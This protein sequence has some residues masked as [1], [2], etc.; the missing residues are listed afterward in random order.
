MV[1]TQEAGIIASII[2]AIVATITL[3][4]SIII[5]RVNGRKT[6]LNIYGKLK[7]EIEGNISA[8]KFFNDDQD[9]PLNLDN[10]SFSKFTA[11]LK[12][13]TAEY[14]NVSGY[15]LS[16]SCAKRK[17]IMQKHGDKI[18]N[19]NINKY[20]I[21]LLG[22]MAKSIRELQQLSPYNNGECKDVNPR[23]RLNNLAESLDIINYFLFVANPEKRKLKD[24]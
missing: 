13:E 4:I 21:D 11:G 16:L 18:K 9:T 1:L 7:H 6:Y 19:K 20:F 8:I 3:L 17:I 24:E 22:T 2:A 10:I 23:R 5:N 14:C 15:K 12:N